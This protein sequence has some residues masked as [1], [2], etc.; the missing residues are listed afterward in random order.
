MYSM[1]YILILIERISKKTSCIGQRVAK[2]INFP[3]ETPA[4]P[5]FQAEL[6]TAFVPSCQDALGSVCTNAFRL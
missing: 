2:W 5:F 4:M 3:A 1:S 6:Q